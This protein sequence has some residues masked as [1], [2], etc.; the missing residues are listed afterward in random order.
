MT[1]QRLRT[2]LNKLASLA[3]ADLLNRLVVSPLL[4][5][6]VGMKTNSCRRTK[7]YYGILCRAS[8][9]SLTRR[10]DSY[11]AIKHHWRYHDNVTKNRLKNWCTFHPGNNVR[12]CWYN[13]ITH[14]GNMVN[15]L[16]LPALI[17]DGLFNVFTKHLIN[18]FIG[19][20]FFF[21]HYHSL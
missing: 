10:V 12:F 11:I 2:N 9:T 13:S 18:P 1:K 8:C 3:G 6:V 7:L 5:I 16:I 14:K 4:A 19:L 20:C 17:E 15:I 21:R